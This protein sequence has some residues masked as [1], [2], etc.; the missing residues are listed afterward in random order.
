MGH[1]LE[2]QVF[3]PIRYPTMSTV[4]A[5]GHAMLTCYR[6]V[7]DKGQLPA[8]SWLSGDYAVDRV[9]ATHL[10]RV[11]DRRPVNSSH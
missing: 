2:F 9:F 1:C 5:V 7:R 11:H 3:R 4:C 10:L 8:L 6:K